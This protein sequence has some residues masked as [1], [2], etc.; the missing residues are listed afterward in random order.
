MTGRAVPSGVHAKRDF[1]ARAASFTGSP[2]DDSTSLLQS[3]R[4]DIVRFAMGSPAPEAIPA[5][6]FAATLATVLP[7]G[8]SDAYG[9]GPTEGEAGLRKALIE[10]LDGQDEVAPP[11]ERLLITSGGM[12]GLDLTCKLFVDPGDVVA[13]ESPTYTNGTGVISGYGGQVLEVPTDED[14]MSVEALRELGAAQ[15]PKL[16]YVIP[17]F[18]N[19][20]GV[21]M[22]LER[23]EQLVEL[24]EAWGTVILEDDP[25]RQLR[26]EGEPLPSLEEL[27]AGAVR[28][29]G[30]HTFSKIL[31][32]GL[33]VGWVSADPEVI[34]WMVAAKQTL[35]TCTN[36]PMQRLVAG[37]M[38]QGLLDRHI[39]GLRADY[40][41]RKEEMRRALA[42]HFGDIG[43]HW[44]DP[45]GGFFLWLTLP[46]AVDCQTLFPMALEQGV[47]FIPGAAFSVSGKFTN[48]LRLAFSGTTGERTELGIRRLRTALD[49]YMEQV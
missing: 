49:L 39:A 29:V 35:D 14:G 16:L 48:A 36:V 4:H 17:N 43:A 13:V 9:Y 5:E 44:T 47:A 32:P 10:F 23:R 18:Q 27:A 34:R 46:E 12:Q 33:R 38:E 21:T 2:I 3:Q 6:I 15:P 8:R 24:A 37:F 42:A 40:H 41:H 26:F 30:V 19:P 20:S 28:V 22:S 7:G 11:G 45:G 31:A 1:A 25:Y